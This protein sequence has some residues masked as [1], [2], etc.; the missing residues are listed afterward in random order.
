MGWRLRQRAHRV[1]R[2]LE[3]THFLVLTAG[4]RR[5]RSNTR[6]RRASRRPPQGPARSRSGRR[7]VRESFAAL[8]GRLAPEIAGCAALVDGLAGAVAVAAAVDAVLAAVRVPA[9]ALAALAGYGIGSSTGAVTFNSLLQTETPEPVRGGVFAAFDVIWQ[10]AG[11]PHSASAACSLTGSAS[12]R[13][14]SPAPC[15]WSAPPQSAAPGSATSA[16]RIAVALPRQPG[17]PRRSRLMPAAWHRR[18]TT[19]VIGVMAGSRTC[20]PS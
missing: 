10:P 1:P 20:P 19:H 18:R 15:S 9:V 17:A 2:W 13:C 12:L 6:S 14:T 8:G 16:E 3:G 5:R 11:W 7:R 4:G